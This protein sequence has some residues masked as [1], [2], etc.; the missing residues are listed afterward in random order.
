MR[1]ALEAKREII[2]HYI[3][4]DGQVTIDRDPSKWS[5]GNG[6]M[7]LGLVITMYKKLGILNDLDVAKFKYAVSYCEDSKGV[8]DRNPG[9]DAQIGHDDITGIVSGSVATDLSFHKDVATHGLKNLF[10][11]NND[12][13]FEL[14]DFLGRQ[15]WHTMYWLIVGRGG[16]FTC[17]LPMLLAK[18]LLIPSTS[19]SILHTYMMLETL[20]SKFKIARI[21]RDKKLPNLMLVEECIR[22]FRTEQHPAVD[23][24]KSVVNK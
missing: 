24:A 12:N 9:R 20:A 7:H 15:I 19:Y 21:V 6:L 4:E 14:R 22:Y 11:Y 10:V 2:E 16:M 13:K 17:F 3:D 23:L 5:T 1:S 18:L 8:Y